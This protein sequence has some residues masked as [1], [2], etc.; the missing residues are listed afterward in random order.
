VGNHEMA[1]NKEYH[2]L[3]CLVAHDS[4]KCLN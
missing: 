1:G 2:R 3:P 4:W